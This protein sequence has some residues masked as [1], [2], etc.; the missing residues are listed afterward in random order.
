MK[1]SNIVILVIIA[2][3]IIIGLWMF[4]SYNSLVTQDE[5]I[6]T[7]WAQV[8]TQYQR[9]FDLVP[10]LVNATKGMLVQEQEVFGKIAEART[11]YAGSNSGTPEKAAAINQYESA[12][13]RL[14]VVMENYPQL[15]SVESI[16]AL[17]DELAGT[18]NRIAVARNRYNNEVRIINTK[19][20]KFP[21]NIVANMLG[22][23]SRELFQ[24]IESAE[25]A[26]V[27]NLIQ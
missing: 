27:V 21:S 1:K 9:R 11:K 3:C 24:S 22:F 13:S 8:E 18:E 26:P 12:L 17:T 14:L 19:V 20:R 7:E 25:T 10:N 23:K 2:I 6:S 15:K 4:G 5:I 16:R